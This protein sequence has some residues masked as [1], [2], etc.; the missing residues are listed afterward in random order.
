MRVKSLELNNYGAFYGKHELPLANRGLTMVLGRNLDEP[1]MDSNGAAKSTM[2]KALDWCL[3]GEVPGG[4]HADSIINEEAAKDCYVTARLEEDDGTALT[5]QRS[6]KLT[7]APRN[8]QVWCNAIEVTTLDDKET[9]RI[10]ETHLGVDREVFHA[11]VYYAQDDTFNFA[12]AKDSE[13]IEILT[14]VLGL[15][16]LDAWL[17]T[18]KE[19]L[20]ELEGSLAAGRELRMRL[21]GQVAALKS[22]SLEPQIMQW[23]QEHAGKIAHLQAQDAEIAAYVVQAA[24]GLEG[25]A[26]ARSELARLES[27]LPA[28]IGMVIIP[29]HLQAEVTNAT[30][31]ARLVDQRLRLANEAVSRL[32]MKR[33]DVPC[34][35][36]GQNL[37]AE[38]LNGESLRAGKE[39]GEA[40]RA[41]EAAS[42]RLKAAQ[43]AHAA[44]L[45]EVTRQQ[46]QAQ[47]AREAAAQAV[48]PQRLAVQQYDKIRAYLDQTVVTQSQIRASLA[49]EQAATN[50]HHQAR[51][52][53]E[54]MIRETET[55]LLNAGNQLV[56]RE[57][58]AKYLE[59]WVQ[60]FGAKGLK[61]YIL[62]TRLQEMTD[63][64]NEWIR[65]LTGGTIW[66]RFETQTM[67][68][69]TKTLSNKINVRVFRYNRNGTIR[70][71]NYRSWSG[72]EKKRVA[73][74]ISFGLSRL[75]AKRA[76]KTYDMLVLDEVF[77]Y[78]DRAGRKAVMEM[79]RVIRR[80]KSSVFVIEH[81]A[82][83]Q[84]AFEHRLL[85]CKEN[86]RSRIEE[87]KHGE[88]T[89]SEQPTPKAKPRRT[90]TSDSVPADAGVLGRGGPPRRR[91]KS[92][93]AASSGG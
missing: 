36:C 21:E 31:E 15:G 43:D 33:L 35:A 83:F 14:K 23:E 40:T 79:L 3:F 82:D 27:L 57:E 61:S 44:A 76:S 56:T 4:D 85:V 19:K 28:G 20:G 30:A 65:I 51:V 11:A 5:V 47:A 13:R 68:R 91:A 54:H 38:H 32:R 88:A 75:V 37:T 69:S 55:Q 67:G 17:E 18:A 52:Q 29:A 46:Q 87:E 66:V 81:D 24:K 9:Q 62:D 41:C 86:E 10:L 78:V 16:Q 53:H 49:R 25:E 77:K 39:L 60:G 58:E 22:V 45:N 6:R 2:F 26:T 90:P 63:A 12:D 73:W 7:G 93:S 70:E 71:R 48:V 89:S 1:C 80:E 59:F 84:G 74:G 8:L 72:G 42:Y 34:P 50:P 64:A 92:G